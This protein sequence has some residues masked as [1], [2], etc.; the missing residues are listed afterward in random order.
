MDSVHSSR[1]SSRA[2]S[3][4]SSK[5][6]TPRLPSSMQN[7][8]NAS[9][10]K[11]VCRFRPQ[12]RVEIEH[13]GTPVIQ[14]QED[15]QSI[16]VNVPFVFISNQRVKIIQVLFHLIECSIHLQT[17]PRFSNTLLNLS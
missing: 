10:I 15:D 7:S 13:G 1:P 2:N 17:K 11:V 12:N 3:L 5:P 8:Q 16:Y 9:N 14:Y 6:G 4:P